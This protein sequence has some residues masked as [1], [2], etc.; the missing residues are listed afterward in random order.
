MLVAQKLYSESVSR[1][2]NER[3]ELKD[4]LSS[5]RKDDIAVVYKI[6]RI[7]RS[8][9]GLI[10]LLNTKKVNLISLDSGDKVV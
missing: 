6:D 7:A 2:D 10:E 8:L 5:L 4:A 3:L 9:K 1:K